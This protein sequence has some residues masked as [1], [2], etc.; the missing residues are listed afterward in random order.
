MFDSLASSEDGEQSDEAYRIGIVVFNSDPAKQQRVK[1]V[2]PGFLEDDNTDNLPWVGPVR[3][4][5]FGLGTNPSSG[6]TF[7]DVKVPKLGSVLAVKFQDGDPK[8][9]LYVGSASTVAVANGMPAQLSTNYPNRTGSWDTLGTVMYRD[10]DTGL[11]GLRH[12][13]GTV[14]EI[15]PNGDIGV[16]CVGVVTGSATQWNVTGNMNITGNVAITGDVTLTGNQSTSGTILGSSTITAVGALRG[17]SVGNTAGMTLEGHH[18]TSG[19]GGYPTSSA[20]A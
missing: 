9:G 17:A 15:Q 5:E 19:G 2:V 20:I 13:S 1:V 11:I 10:L 8:H 4:S 12:K 7:G 16:A 18:H 6:L 3:G 14:L